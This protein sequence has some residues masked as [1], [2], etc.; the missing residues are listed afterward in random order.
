M[1]L[2]WLLHNYQR[3]LLEA[4]YSNPFKGF[5]L[6]ELA[7]LSGVDPGNTARYLDKFAERKIIRIDKSGR[8]AKAHADLSNPETRKI[9]E[10]FELNRTKHFM[11]ALGARRPHVEAFAKQLTEA[12]P[13][14]RLIGIQDAE[15][16]LHDWDMTVQIAVVVGSKND[17][18]SV[19]AK[20]QEMADTSNLKHK[21]NICVYSSDALPSSWNSEKCGC[22]GYW[23][24]RAILYGESYYWE[25]IELQS[26]CGPDGTAEEMVQ[27][28]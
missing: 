8:R 1:T 2:N 16:A 4:L 28:A 24:D 25:L 17:L 27:N 7:R 14:I 12:F 23:E 22:L 10:L 21:L 5:Y 19:H 15:K 6:S 13:D 3:S 18:A 26:R 20:C 9:F 11:E